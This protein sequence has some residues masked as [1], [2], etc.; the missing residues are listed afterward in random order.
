M[1]TTATREARIVC[2]W[3]DDLGAELAAIERAWHAEHDGHAD[4][5]RAA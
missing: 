1:E 3:L 5:E 2:I 4:A